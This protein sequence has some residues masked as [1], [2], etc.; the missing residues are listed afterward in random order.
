ML[1]YLLVISHK[2]SHNLISRKT[3]CTVREND[4]ATRNDMATSKRHKPVY[5]LIE[6]ILYNYYYFCCH[7]YVNWWWYERRFEIL[8]LWCY[9]LNILINEHIVLFS[10]YLDVFGLCKVCEQLI[11][12]NKDFNQEDFRINKSMTSFLKLFLYWSNNRLWI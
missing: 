2:S 4:A 5:E 12:L 1:V 6:D 10:H 3:D 8:S 9:L 11:I 7:T